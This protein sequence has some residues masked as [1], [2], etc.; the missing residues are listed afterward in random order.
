MR[1]YSAWEEGEGLY[2]N[3]GTLHIPL[4]NFF[5]MLHMVIHHPCK[6]AQA[7]VIGHVTR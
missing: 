3:Q 4:K 5:E 2:L 7:L 6:I 1:M